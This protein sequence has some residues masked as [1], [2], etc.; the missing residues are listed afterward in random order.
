MLSRRLGM[1]AATVLAVLAVGAVAA[2]AATPKDGLFVGKTDPSGKKIAIKVSG[3]GD[4]ATV[5][6]CGY[7]MPSKIKAGRFNAAYKGPGGTYVAVKGSFPT[8]RTA[9]GEITVDFLCDTQ[10]EKFTARLK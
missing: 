6:Y 3:G 7:A 5:R 4:K 8:K 2:L 1:L 10:G 9:K